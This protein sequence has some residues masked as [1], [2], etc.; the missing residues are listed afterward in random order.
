MRAFGDAKDTVHDKDRQKHFEHGKGVILKHLHRLVHSFKTPRFAQ[1][2][3]AAMDNTGEAWPEN[4][5]ALL[6]ALRGLQQFSNRVP[7]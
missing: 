3:S 5:L 2:Y 6:T 1:E 7:P 4:S